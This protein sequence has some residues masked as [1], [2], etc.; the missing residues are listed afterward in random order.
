M[1]YV[2]SHHGS[3]L[4]VAAQA[5]DERS[6]SHALKQLKP[7]LFLDIDHNEQHRCLEYKV[8]LRYAKDQPPVFITAW[9]DEHDR[10]LPLSHA[11]IELVKKLIE[12]DTLREAREANRRMRER[13]QQ[14]MGD[15][16][17]A[18]AADMLPRIHGRKATVLH[19][20]VHL[21]RSRARR[22]EA[23]GDAARAAHEQAERDAYNRRRAAR[24]LEPR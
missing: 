15:E 13:S 1:G 3:N 5:A 6:I 2:V 10:P 18:V 21:R 9:R 16:I 19:R 12:T 22:E 4:L 7:G 14:E 24:G 23:A 20:G 17:E 11:L 8:R